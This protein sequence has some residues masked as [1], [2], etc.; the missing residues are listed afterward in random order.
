M[1]I[2]SIRYR[3]DA[4]VFYFHLITTFSL[5]ISTFYYETSNFDRV[6]PENGRV[7]EKIHGIS[8]HALET[9]RGHARWADMS[10]SSAGYFAHWL[11]KAFDKTARCR[12][13]K[14]H[15]LSRPWLKSLFSCLKTVENVNIIKILN[16]I[17]YIDDLIIDT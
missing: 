16:P 10:R 5:C 17:H 7:W 12:V 13:N 3:L 11:R 2:L 4:Y 14:S 1:S 15:D 9:T 6:L 8:R